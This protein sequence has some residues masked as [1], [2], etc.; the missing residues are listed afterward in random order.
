MQNAKRWSSL[1]DEILLAGFRENR[2][3]RDIAARL[4]R[5]EGAVLE[6]AQDLGLGNAQPQPDWRMA[7]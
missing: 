1:E 5:R 3:L 2:E 7:A 6:R 4:G